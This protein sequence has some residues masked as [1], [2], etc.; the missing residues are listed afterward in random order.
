VNVKLGKPDLRYNAGNFFPM[1]GLSVA[2]L[3]GRPNDAVL[4]SM[5]LGWQYRVPSSY[6]EM[7]QGGQKR[8]LLIL[9]EYVNKTEK[10]GGM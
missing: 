5:W 2:Y 3:A 7:L 8:K 4:I 9:S 1:C 10:I 6:C